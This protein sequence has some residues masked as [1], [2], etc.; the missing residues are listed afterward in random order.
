MTIC[1]AGTD[2]AVAAAAANPALTTDLLLHCVRH[3]EVVAPRTSRVLGG[4]AFRDAV[5]LPSEVS[6][7]ES[8]FES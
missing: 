7:F 8:E 3:A 6:E 2:D 5:A 4:G 1:C